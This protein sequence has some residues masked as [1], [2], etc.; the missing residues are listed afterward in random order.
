MS[1]AHDPWE[2]TVMV[3]VFGE[4]ED[5]TGEGTEQANST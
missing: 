5:D 4:D 2:A 1:G 3:G